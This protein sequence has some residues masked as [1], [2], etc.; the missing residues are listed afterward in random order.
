MKPVYVFL[1][2][3]FEDIEALAVVDILR[4]GKVDVKTVS[5]SDKKSV[6][7]SHGVTVMADMLFGEAQ[8]D[9]AAML[10]LPGG[11]PGAANLN[12]HEGLRK[13]LEKQNAEG[14]LIGAICAAPMVLGGL[15]ILRGKKA[16]CYP[17]FEQYLEGADCTGESVTVCDNIVTGNG[18]A[19]VF[20][21]AYSI[22]ATLTD[23]D[24]AN[25]VAD[26][27]QF[28]KMLDEQA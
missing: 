19:A 4:R 25:S 2:N 24:T 10:V 5:I 23:D 20:P 3:G 11:M 27:M 28:F 21:F 9:D 13:A 6:E 16:T 18:P 7:S 8:T 1:A 14:R 26:G 12:S 17:G 15:G 22:L